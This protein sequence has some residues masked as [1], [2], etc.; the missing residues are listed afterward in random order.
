MY[1]VKIINAPKAGVNGDYEGVRGCT[2]INCS[3]RV[4]RFPVWGRSIE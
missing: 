3:D 1:F 4:K 2:L